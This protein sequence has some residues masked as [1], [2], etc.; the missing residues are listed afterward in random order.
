MTLASQDGQEDEIIQ[1]AQSLAIA[2]AQQ[3]L[4]KKKIN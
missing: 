2:N 4:I 1:L 3:M